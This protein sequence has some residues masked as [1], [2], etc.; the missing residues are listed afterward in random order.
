MQILEH[1]MEWQQSYQQKVLKSYHETGDFSFRRYAYAN[2]LST[3]RTGFGSGEG[4]NHVHLLQWGVPH[5]KAG[6]I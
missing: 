1:E 5:R 3:S 4:P 2:N 6:S